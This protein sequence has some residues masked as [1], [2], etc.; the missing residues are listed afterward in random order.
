MDFDAK[1][2]RKKGVERAEEPLAARDKG[3]FGENFVMV[4]KA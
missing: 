3:H 2:S 4:P 1:P